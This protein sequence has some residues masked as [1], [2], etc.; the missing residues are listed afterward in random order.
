MCDC[1]AHRSF[2]DCTCHCD[3][4][5]DR[6]MQ[7][8]EKLR[9]YEEQCESRWRWLESTKELQETLGFTLP[10]ANEAL[11]RYLQWNSVGVVTELG[12]ALQEVGWKPWSTPQGWIHRQA[13]L[14][15]L[16]DV[17]HFLGNMLVAAGI[18]DEEWE[19]AYQR[20]QQVNRDRHVNN[21]YDSRKDKCPACG[22]SYDD[23]ATNCKPLMDD[24]GAP[25][26]ED[27]GDL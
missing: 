6:W 24:T 4:T 19:E 27:Y 13:F 21:S 7:L 14:G 11:S 16:V 9:D 18:T 22:R 17:G 1:E 8:R 15:E 20:K 2:V 5:D 12:E 25:H 23:V 3:H 10:L 26:C